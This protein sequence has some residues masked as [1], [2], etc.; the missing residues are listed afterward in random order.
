MTRVQPFTFSGAR[1]V[2]TGAA[3]GIGEQT[4]YQLAARGTDLILVDRDR[5]R[6]AAVAERIRDRHAVGVHTEAVDLADA[7]EVDALIVRIRAMAPTIDLLVNN[8]GVALGGAFTDVSAE[9]FDWVL[10]VNFHAPVALC[11]GLLSSIP[12]GGHIVNVSS[13]YGL[14][15]PAG[16][17]AYSSSKFALRGFSEVLRHELAERSIG[18]TTV[19]P[20]GIRT[21]IAETARVGANVNPEEAAAGKAEFAKLLTYPADK[22][23][24]EIIQGVHKRRGRVLIASSAVVSD[25]VA[26]AFPE[27]YGAILNQLVRAI[28]ASRRGPQ[29]EATQNEPAQPSPSNPSAVHEN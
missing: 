20:G 14:I 7:G 18:V 26:R 5:E 17:A 6:L 23:A 21:R 13:L 27:H 3:S 10:A 16:Q 8:A 4:A 12:A 28:R 24:A 11:R 29:Q 2:L 15:G 25:L 1:A 9:E 19:H 22:A